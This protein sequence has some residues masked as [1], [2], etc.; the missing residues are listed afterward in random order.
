[1]SLTPKGKGV[2]KISGLSIPPISRPINLANELKLVRIN[3]PVIGSFTRLSRPF[4]HYR[5]R[6]VFAVVHEITHSNKLS[7]EMQHLIGTIARP[8]IAQVTSATTALS[9][10]NSQVPYSHILLQELK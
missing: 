6:H 4:I 1:V 9:C 8:M 10:S 5:L 3:F 7:A 2:V